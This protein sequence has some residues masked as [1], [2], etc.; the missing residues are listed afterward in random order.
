MLMSTFPSFELLKVLN[1]PQFVRIETK[2]DCIF[3]VGQV[4]EIS[5]KVYITVQ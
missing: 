4:I 3:K 2:F 1:K 5:L